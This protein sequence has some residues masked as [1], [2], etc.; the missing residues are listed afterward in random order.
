MLNLS[1]KTQPVGSI[2]TM[3]N[4]P[5]R[6]L[7]ERLQKDRWT[8]FESILQRTTSEHISEFV[9]A[10][11]LLLN[12]EER[13]VTSFS[14]VELVAAAKLVKGG[15]MTYAHYWFWLTESGRCARKTLL[16]SAQTLL[17]PEVVTH[18]P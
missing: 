8:R 4:N 7:A 14:R 6:S 16:L 9:P 17:A 18:G 11:I 5:G 13:D 1:E 3:A 12:N 10:L 15:L 2:S